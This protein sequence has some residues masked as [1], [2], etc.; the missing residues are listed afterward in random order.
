MP[1][2]LRVS[3]VTSPTVAFLEKVRFQSDAVT[4]AR[5]IGAMPRDFLGH[6]MGY[7]DHPAWAQ[8]RIEGYR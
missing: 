5:S 4:T 8:V 6:L 2:S 3:P 1:A 7:V